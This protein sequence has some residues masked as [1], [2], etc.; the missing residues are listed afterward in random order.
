MALYNT[1]GGFFFFLPQTYTWDYD[2]TTQVWKCGDGRR[3]GHYS[4]RSGSGMQRHDGIRGVMMPCENV[5]MCTV[6]ICDSHRVYIIEFN[7][8]QKVSNASVT[9]C[10][11]HLQC[12]RTRLS[13]ELLKIIPQSDTAT[14]L[15]TFQSIIFPGSESF[16]YSENLSLC[17]FLRYL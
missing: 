4:H 10:R 3:R 15:V 8:C 7:L 1:D 2:F 14:K 13:T 17:L 6:G 11:C 5:T 12:P 9:L 16:V